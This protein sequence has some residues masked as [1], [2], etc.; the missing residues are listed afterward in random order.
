MRLLTFSVSPSHLSTF[1]LLTFS[2][3]PF[4]LLT[5]TFPPV[6]LFHKVICGLTSVHLLVLYLVLI[7]YID[8]H[9]QVCFGSYT[10]CIL[11]LFLST[12]SLTIRWCY[13]ISPQR[14]HLFATPHVV[15]T[16]Q[17][18]AFLNYPS[19]SSILISLPSHLPC[20]LTSPHFLPFS[21]ISP[22][23]N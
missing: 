2:V 21:A 3:S 18:P 20:P 10:L 15:S 13:N 7:L 22:D 16:S 11:S 1:S 6:H 4:Y 14:P 8:L 9:H 12:I 5:K 17:C 19:T 23:F